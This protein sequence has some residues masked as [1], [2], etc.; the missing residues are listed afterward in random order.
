MSIKVLVFAGS[1]RTGSLNERLASHAVGV[2]RELGVE[3]THASLRDFPLP[4][5]DG[6]L[7]RESGVPQQ[8]QDFGA[9][10]G[11][12]QGVFIVTPEYN[13]GMPPLLKNTLDWVSRIRPSTAFRDRVF[14]LG[15]GSDGVLGGYRALIHVRH[16]MELGLGAL[17]QPQMVSVAHASR[18]LGMDGTLDDEN[19]AKTA[20]STLQALIDN[21]RRFA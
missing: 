4:I 17:V 10:I 1:V 20:R 9:L 3:V 11:Q 19:A 8:A 5:Y 14:G 6:D 15:S 18:V 21:A 12:H 13:A 7:E 2:L 16:T